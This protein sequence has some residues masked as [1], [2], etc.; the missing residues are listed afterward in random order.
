MIKDSLSSNSSS[1][2]VFGL[3]AQYN[4]TVPSLCLL[5]FIE[6]LVP[7]MVVE[8]CFVLQLL[9]VHGNEK[10]EGGKFVI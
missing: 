2:L 9:T 8:M 4:F 1:V 6:N 7:N 3:L 10:I 5:I